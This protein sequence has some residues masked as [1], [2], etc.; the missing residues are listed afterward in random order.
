MKKL[1]LASVFA[2]I[3]VAIVFIARAAPTIIAGSPVVVNNASA[4]TSVTPAFS[5]NPTL[6]QFQI[7][8]GALGATTDIALKIY[9]GVSGSTNNCV[10][11]YTW[12]PS[13]TNATTETVPAGVIPIPNYVFG[14]ITT[15][16]SQSL[17]GSYG[18]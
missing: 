5:Y 13:F 16:N 17:Y 15:T 1:I 2:L 3:A 8:H 14:T 6:Q 18:Q 11:V 7:T 10:Q 12:Y 4:N 9:V